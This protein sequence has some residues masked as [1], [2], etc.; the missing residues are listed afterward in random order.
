MNNRFIIVNNG[1]ILTHHAK[2]YY[3]TAVPTSAPTRIENPYNKKAPSQIPGALRKN[4][5]GEYLQ[6]L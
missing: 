5:I 4:H 2:T 3:P 1:V 6:P